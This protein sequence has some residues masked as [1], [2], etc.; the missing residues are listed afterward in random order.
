M[1]NIFNIILDKIGY[2]IIKW[3]CCTNTH[4][5]VH[6]SLCGGCKKYSYKLIEIIKNK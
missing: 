5:S 6:D 1:I 4:H 2:K 3:C